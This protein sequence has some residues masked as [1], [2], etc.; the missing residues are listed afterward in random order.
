MFKAG[1]R[2][3]RRFARVPC[4]LVAA[5]LPSVCR[6]IRF[7]PSAAS[8]SASE[9]GNTLGLS[10]ELA[11]YAV[12]AQYPQLRDCS[13][14]L[15]PQCSLAFNYD[16]DGSVTF[17]AYQVSCSSTLQLCCTPVLSLYDFLPE[18]RAQPFK[19]LQ[20]PPI[21]SDFKHTHTNIESAL[22]L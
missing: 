17:D 21:E 12:A 15:P 11:C 16:K 14:L 5:F 6:G 9:S 10:A 13:S 1:R 22:P 8:I 20:T 19:A 2:A 3:Y 4:L 18:A 7:L